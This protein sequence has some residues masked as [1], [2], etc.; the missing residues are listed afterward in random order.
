MLKKL[1]KYEFKATARIFFM[2]YALLVA[3]AAINHLLLF[4]GD[5]IEDG[6]ALAIVVGILQGIFAFIYGAAVISSGIVTVV[7]ILIRF[8]R[9][10]MG[11]EGHLMFTLPVAPHHHLLSKLIVSAI[12]AVCTVAVIILSLMVILLRFGL[13][14][15]IR[16]FLDAMA[17]EGFVPFA[18]I[19]GIGIFLLIAII[20]GIMQVYCAM[21]IGPHVTRSRLGGSIIAYIA[22]Y[23]LSQIFAVVCLFGYALV[24]GID[25]LQF[26]IEQSHDQASFTLDLGTAGV[27]AING[28]GIATFFITI[29]PLITLGIASY[30]VSC[31]ML[32]KKLSIA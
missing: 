24:P 21:C 20:C 17:S 13:I 25:A 28:I 10:L 11:D 27:D 31:R 14:D 12:W 29:V 9:N 30:V 8:Y 16:Q 18:W 19:T 6:T 15:G 22:I 7:I 32:N 5:L 23:L 4:V 2:I 3:M 26:L 1:I